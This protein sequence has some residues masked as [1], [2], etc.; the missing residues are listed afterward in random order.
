MSV[1]RSLART[2]TASEIKSWITKRMT[3]TKVSYPTSADAFIASCESWKDFQT[4]AAALSI[5][6]QAEAFSRLTQI[7]LQTD[8]V[9]RNVLVTEDVWLRKNVPGEICSQLRL[10]LEGIDLIAR[11]RDNGFWAFKSTFVAAGERGP[12]THA[13]S[14]FRSLA[15]ERCREI[16]DLPHPPKSTSELDS[17]GRRRWCLSPH[18]GCG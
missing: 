15:F 10:P 5:E 1:K 11:T 17:T 18:H 2:L 6:R 4:S 13:A 8:S 14:T 16:S 3:Q 7:H 12:D 9:Y